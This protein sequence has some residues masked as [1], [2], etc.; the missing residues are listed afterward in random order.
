MLG[1]TG[2]V[3]LRLCGETEDP[4]PCG[5]T[6]EWDPKVGPWGGTLGWN[7]GFGP[8]GGILRR[9]YGVG[10]MPV[11]AYRKK[12][13]ETLGWDPGLWGWNKGWDPEVGP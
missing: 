5:E 6:M 3:G 12:G 8:Q 10:P 11:R 1:H 2:K 9:D 7:H 13:T 4:G